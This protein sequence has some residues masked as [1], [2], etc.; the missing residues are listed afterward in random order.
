MLLVIIYVCP[1]ICW[2]VSIYVYVH[3]SCWWIPLTCYWWRVV[4]V[5]MYW[6]MLVWIY[7]IH[8]NYVLLLSSPKFTHNCCWI[9]SP[10]W[11]WIL[12]Y[13]FMRV[14][15]M[16]LLHQGTASEMKLI[17]HEPRVG[18]DTLYVLGRVV[19]AYVF[20]VNTCWC[21]C[22]LC[23]WLQLMNLMLVHIL[24]KIIY[25]HAYLWKINY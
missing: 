18:L 2:L 12:M 19:F 7:G 17:S 15:M 10:C 9:S 16:C 5:S 21:I 6:N 1:H 11:C 22:V 24:M 4:D 20:E 23:D 3:I 8:M 13:S 14:V 25:V